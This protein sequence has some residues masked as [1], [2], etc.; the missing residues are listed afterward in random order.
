MGQLLAHCTAMAGLSGQIVNWLMGLHIRHHSTGHSSFPFALTI[1]QSTPHT[2][3]LRVRVDA[4]DAHSVLLDSIAMFQEQMLSLITRPGCSL[5][6]YTVLPGPMDEPAVRGPSVGE[7]QHR[8]NLG[9]T[10]MVI[11]SGTRVLL[12]QLVNTQ[13]IQLSAQVRGQLTCLRFFSVLSTSVRALQMIPTVQAFTA[14]L[15]EAGE[16]AL[17]GSYKDGA[18][19]ASRLEVPGAAA[20]S[21]GIVGTLSPSAAEAAAV[22]SG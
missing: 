5:K 12:L 1:E 4:E 3:L 17:G 22:E 19:W 14:A 2:I 11:K 16:H 9:E 20:S 8:V 21:S 15:E 10:E 13:P 6:S 18:R 7:C